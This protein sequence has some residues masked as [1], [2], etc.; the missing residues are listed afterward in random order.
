MTSTVSDR[1][2]ASGQPR[3]LP[4]ELQTRIIGII[5]QKIGR[6][7]LNREAMGDL[8]SCCLVSKAWRVRRSFPE[9][10]FL[11]FA[12]KLLTICLSSLQ[13][14][15]QRL[16]Y[17]TVSLTE[18]SEAQEFAFYESIRKRPAL[19]PLVKFLR[20]RRAVNATERLLRNLAL[21]PALTEIQNFCWTPAIAKMSPP[22]LY[23]RPT[24]EDLRLV[25]EADID[26]ADISN[27]DGSFVL[28][29]AWFDLDDLTVLGARG[30][31]LKLLLPTVLP[32][33]PLKLEA[34]KI[35]NFNGQRLD[36][37][38]EALRWRGQ[39][40]ERLYLTP[41]ST[42]VRPEAHGPA[43]NPLSVLPKLDTLYL[44]DDD[45]ARLLH[46]P[47]RELVT[48]T[49]GGL[50]YERYDGD[51][52]E[53]LTPTFLADPTHAYRLFIDEVC[54][55]V[56]LTP[57]RFPS[58]R[59]VGL[60]SPRAYKSISFLSRET[61]RMPGILEIAEQLKTAGLTF[62]DMNDV[63]WRDEWSAEAT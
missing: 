37:I 16:L 49:V 51:T 34:V 28:L 59:R 20:L 30:Y 63:E 45:F 31:N 10:A 33:L 6:P 1:S 11:G 3:P 58:L 56:S 53:D 60:V 26:A 21:L 29:Q 61:C 50:Y 13:A 41:R 19:S 48:L 62:F 36:A 14:E 9:R 15:G 27:T 17:A 42:T 25:D 35:K 54:R 44:R 22:V 38:L 47:H 24:L 32:F 39:T 43:L 7:P 8:L 12:A 5:K 57:S 40:L 2:R 52:G 46:V 18:H 55:V 23:T 4:L